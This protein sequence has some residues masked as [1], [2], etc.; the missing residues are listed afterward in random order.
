MSRVGK[1]KIDLKPLT[2]YK[3]EN[4]LLM[5][6]GKLGTKTL[7]VPDFLII[8]MDEL[9]KSM[10]INLKNEEEK[11]K[12]HMAMQGTTVRLIKNLIT[13]VTVGFTKVFLFKGLGYRY[14]LENSNKLLNM[15]LGYSHPVF[16]KIPDGI[17]AVGLKQDKLELKSTDNGLLGRYGAKL[18]TLRKWNPYSGKGIMEENDKPKSKEVVKA[19]K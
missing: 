14:V 12:H 16:L 13:G 8:N 17:T 1:E 6:E 7:L 4:N 11:I 15:Q 19:K 9:Q 5:V 18:K 3:V 10:S 2:K